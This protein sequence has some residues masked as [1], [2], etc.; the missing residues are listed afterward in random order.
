MGPNILGK[1]VKVGRTG[2]KKPQIKCIHISGETLAEL[3]HSELSS[4]LSQHNQRMEASQA[5][6]PRLLPRPEGAGTPSQAPQ[7]SVT[8]SFPSGQP[9]PQTQE[10]TSARLSVTPVH[11]EGPLVRQ[12][13][14]TDVPSRLHRD[15]KPRCS[16]TSVIAEASPFA[17]PLSF[18]T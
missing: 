8:Y 6:I 12:E 16:G 3:G 1:A 2:S 18:P 15:S 17:L 11:L 7:S 4:F 14:P 9:S 13:T 10:T 5:R